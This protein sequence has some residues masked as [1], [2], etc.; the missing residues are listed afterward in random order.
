MIET[1]RERSSGSALV[2]PWTRWLPAL[3]VPALIATGALVNASRAG[4][5]V[6][7]PDKSAEQVLAMIGESAVDA[8]SGTLEQVSD[9]GLPALPT[10]GASSGTN[11]GTAS[12]AG[13]ALELLTGSHTAR[14][15]LDGPTR[16]R[17]QVL[18]TL[19]ERD[20][21]RNDREIWLYSSAENAATHLVLPVSATAAEPGEPAAPEPTTP[22]GV[23]TPAELAAKLLTSMDASTR[24]AVGTDA[25]VAGRPAYELTLTPRTT[26]TLVGSVSIAVDS[27]TGLP[28]GVTIMARGQSEPAF[29][30]AFTQLSL[31]TPPTERFDFVP[32]PGATVTE[33]QM[34]SLPS[35]RPGVGTPDPAGLLGFG[36]P[37][38]TGSG[39]ATVVEVPLG[40]AAPMLTRS[41]LLDQLART[42]AGG[43]L[44]ESA[45]VTV[46]L[47]DDG[48]LLV[49]SVP[50]ERL[51]ATA[52]PQ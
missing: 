15:Y 5:S 35:A 38:V 49:G 39:W 52:A 51:L 44:L 48:R 14:V 24:V 10:D 32:P 12:G 42:V 31:Q 25:L 1:E 18:D 6:D 34:P 41:P 2:R 40:L 47:T 20:A 33:Q 43:Q 50:P 3:I 17:V 22:G 46:L 21:I 30:V 23:E 36:E 45:L 9:L 26:G 8:M 27:E 13:M 37:T 7:L 4:A 19:A 28:L 11:S 16:S 29:R